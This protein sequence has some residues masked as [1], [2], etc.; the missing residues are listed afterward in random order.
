IPSPGGPIPTPLP[1]PFAGKLDGQLSS[2]VKIA[3]KAAAVNGSTATNS[4][5]HVPQGGSFQKPP[6]NSGTVQMGSTT[7]MINGKQGQPNSAT[8]RNLAKL[9]V[10]E[11]LRD[12]PRIAKVEEVV[13]GP[14]VGQPSLV[15]VSVRVLP[16]GEATEVLIGPF[17]LELAQ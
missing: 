10:L 9:F 2:D 5:S 7:V 11:S 13:V 6:A 4:P 1:H 8:R 14:V 17:R 15:D 3:G 16:V 12:E